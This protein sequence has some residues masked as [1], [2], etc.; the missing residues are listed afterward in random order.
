VVS[1]QK[2]DL[3]KNGGLAIRFVVPPG[4][5]FVGKPH[6]RR[7][8]SIPFRFSGLMRAKT[9]TANCGL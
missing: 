1:E 8:A 2:L 4:W 9:G 5:V 7:I 6:R 3:H